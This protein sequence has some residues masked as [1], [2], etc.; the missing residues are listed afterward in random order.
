MNS[1]KEIKDFINNN[2]DCEGCLENFIDK[3]NTALENID[4]KYV[5]T[6]DSDEHRWY[7][8]STVIY[9]VIKDN[10]SLGYIGIS[11]VTTLKSETSSYEDLYIDIEAFEV[12]KVLKESFEII[13][14]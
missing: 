12:K 13:K 6:L 2:S 7:I 8:I 9:E 11:E 1:I 3:Y 10:N 5:E 4:F 14:E